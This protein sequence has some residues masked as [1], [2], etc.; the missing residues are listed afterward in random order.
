MNEFAPVYVPILQT[1]QAEIK[2]LV[3][4]K[5]KD[6]IYPLLVDTLK[7]EEDESGGL[8]NRTLTKLM[9]GWS[10]ENPIMVDGIHS[11][12][13]EKT[14]EAVY[15][16]RLRLI[17][18]TGPTRNSKYQSI[19]REL[20]KNTNDGLALRLSFD[21][22]ETY[23]GKLS[24]FIEEQFSLVPKDCDLIVDLG[25]ID[26][27]SASYLKRLYPTIF[28]QIDNPNSWRTFV[29]ASGAF[30][31]NLNSV[32]SNSKTTFERSDF[33][34]WQAITQM[35]IENHRT[36][37]FGDYGIDAP[38]LP[39]VSE[40]QRRSAP[41]CRYCFEDMWHIYKGSN[42]KI[43][44]E[45]GTKPSAKTGVSFIDIAKELIAQSYYSG[46][47]FS[48]GDQYIWDTAHTKDARG[49]G[50]T[51]WRETG[52]SHHLEFVLNQLSSSSGS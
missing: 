42:P 21:E 12:D 14:I 13:F 39:I 32:E 37:I 45:K 29:I 19:V 41:N 15:A 44:K 31:K 7:L 2:A 38:S 27:Q 10:E 40:Q 30:P 3:S 17:P 23:K 22:L 34:L 25:A 51:N 43:S 1:R 20:V 49:G 46:K 48:A 28:S 36:P 24:E 50:P 26:S 18:V 33:L 52:F 16:A 5:N 4:L 9:K 6:I 8:S 35:K 47:E 11:S